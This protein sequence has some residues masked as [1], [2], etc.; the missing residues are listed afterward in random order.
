MKRESKS[1]LWLGAGLAT[2]FGIGLLIAVGEEQN[3]PQRYSAGALSAAEN[4]FDFGTI[5]MKEG[6]VKHRFEIINNSQTPV[7]IEKIYTSCMCTTA[8]VINTAGKV[9]GKFG[10]PGH[11][12]PLRANIE[13][14]AQETV[15]ID[16]VFDPNA[17]G[18]AGVG[19]AER[20]IY[21]ET[22]SAKVPK[23]ELLFRAL[24]TP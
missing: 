4:E 17:H 23:L 11:G 18:P 15:F 8:S 9:L 16:A 13:V 6:R 5:S 20:S 2:I 22:N 7:K 12:F 19:L 14:A 24:V 21:L 10:M 1:L 3:L